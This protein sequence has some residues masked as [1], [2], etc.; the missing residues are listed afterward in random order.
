MQNGRTILVQFKP[1]QNDRTVLVHLAIITVTNMSKHYA[2]DIKCLS[3]FEVH[4][5]TLVITLYVFSGANKRVGHVIKFA[6]GGFS[7]SKLRNYP[8]IHYIGLRMASV[9]G[10]R[11]TDKPSGTACNVKCDPCV[12]SGLVKEACAIL[13]TMRGAYVCRMCINAQRV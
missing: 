4:C 8:I 6:V 9:D 11:P 2:E 1:L 3:G 13:S 5:G 10:A 7:L 12:H